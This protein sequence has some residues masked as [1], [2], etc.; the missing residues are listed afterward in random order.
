[1]LNEIGDLSVSKYLRQN[2]LGF[3][4]T[5][6]VGLSPTPHSHESLIMT[7]YAKLGECCYSSALSAG[8]AGTRM[9]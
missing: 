7:D 6:Y 8:R 5:V 3:F 4:V 2:P 9:A 1:M